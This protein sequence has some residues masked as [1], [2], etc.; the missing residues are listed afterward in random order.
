MPK[1]LEDKHLNQTAGDLVESLKS[2]LLSRVIDERLSALKLDSNT[3]LISPSAGEY[4]ISDLR[5]KRSFIISSMTHAGRE[6]E[7][8]NSLHNEAL[9]ITQTPITQSELDRAKSRLR[10]FNNLRYKERDFRHSD[11]LADTYAKTASVAESIADDGWY[12]QLSNQVLDQVTPEDLRLLAQKWLTRENQVV[13]INAKKMPASDE[14]T[15]Q[16]ILKILSTKKAVVPKTSDAIPPFVL[17]DLPAAGRVVKAS[18]NKRMDITR[19]Q[20]SNGVVVDIL[21]IKGFESTIHFK[22]F[23]NGGTSLIPDEAMRQTEW[24]FDGLDEAGFSGYDAHSLELLLSDKILKVDKILEPGFHGVEG[25]FSPTHTELTLALVHAKMARLNKDADAFTRYIQRKSAQVADY[26]S[27]RDKAFDEFQ[28]AIIYK[29]NPR[30]TTNQPTP[31]A[32]AQT[33]YDL[34]YEQ[35]QKIFQNANGQHFI[36]VGDLDLDTLKP[37][38]EKYIGSLPS[39]PNAPTS[40]IDRGYRANFV[41]GQFVLK[42][43]HEPLA[44]VD[45]NHFGTTPYSLEDAWAFWILGQTLELRLVEQLR[46]KMGGTYS[47]KAYGNLDAHPYATY[48][49]NASFSC[50]PEHTQALIQATQTELNSIIKRGPTPSELDK[51][52]KNAASLIEAGFGNNANIADVLSSAHKNHTSIE[53]LLNKAE[54]MRGVRAQDVSNIGKKLLS[55]QPMVFIMQPE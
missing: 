36:F 9:R 38:I 5:V 34:A 11:E 42:Q 25:A 19:W 50:A 55:A 41:P 1:E 48:T 3:A 6:L 28:D 26:G 33:N 49:F 7:G 10:A 47:V 27:D 44:K 54:I 22:S 18:F 2:G 52:R 51:I 29:N 45:I 14:E 13:L 31:N 4:D 12:N 24:A 37:L 32:L 43:G 39:N 30:V 23:A 15:T 35:H 53:R 21:P 8:L 40:Y 20:L 46:E 17:K 16:A